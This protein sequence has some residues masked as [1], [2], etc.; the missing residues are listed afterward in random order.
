VGDALFELLSKSSSLLASYE[1]F[2]LKD[3]VQMFSMNGLND[4]TQ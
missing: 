1:P 3:L 2:K 4:V